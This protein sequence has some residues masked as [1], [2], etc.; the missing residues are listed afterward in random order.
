MKSRRLGWKAEPEDA[1]SDESRSRVKKVKL[2]GSMAG[3]SRRSGPK[4]RLEG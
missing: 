1:R 3:A 2:E 4:A